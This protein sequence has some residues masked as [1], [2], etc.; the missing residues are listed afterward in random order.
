M[1][2][3]TKTVSGSSAVKNDLNK[4][5]SSGIDSVLEEM[6]GPKAVSTIAKTSID[7]DNYK[8]QE[9]LEDDL[10]AASKEG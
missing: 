9:G 2:S 10:N 7:W 3:V 5:K 8:E 6:K 1:F 4:K